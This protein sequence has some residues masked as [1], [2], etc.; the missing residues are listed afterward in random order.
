M[1]SLSDDAYQLW[2]E[3]EV[4]QAFLGY[5]K[6]ELNGLKTQDRVTSRSIEQIAIDA[7][8]TQSEI[9]CL[10]KVISWRPKHG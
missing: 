10:Q 5:V 1:S 7:I 6:Q 2:L 9:D 3:N 4:T 8:A